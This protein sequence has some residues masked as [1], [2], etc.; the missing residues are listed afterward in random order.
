M[1]TIH[2]G[3][4]VWERKGTMRCPASGLNN[5]LEGCQAG[6]LQ[7]WK[8]DQLGGRWAVMIRSRKSSAVNLLLVWFY[9]VVCPGKGKPFWR[10]LEKRQK[11]WGFGGEG[12]SLHVVSMKEKSTHVNLAFEENHVKSP[13]TLTQETEAI[14]CRKHLEITKGNVASEKGQNKI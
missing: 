2:W 6:K 10:P 12:E 13:S 7:R 5:W 1:S 4:S 11:P 14:F 3:N 9:L 8:G